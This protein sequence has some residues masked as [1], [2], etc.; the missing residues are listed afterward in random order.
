MFA[1]SYLQDQNCNVF[2]ARNS[3]YTLRL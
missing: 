1:Q 2:R 3:V